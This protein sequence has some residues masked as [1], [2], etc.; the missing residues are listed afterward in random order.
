M[1]AEFEVRWLSFDCGIV[2]VYIM[3]AN[4]AENAETFIVNFDF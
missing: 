3:A 2:H 4:N 1:T